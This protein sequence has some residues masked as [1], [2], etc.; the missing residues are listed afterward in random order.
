MVTLL[1]VLQL[2]LMQMLPKQPVVVPWKR[3]QMQQQIQVHLQPNPLR[4]LS[5]R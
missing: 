1:L 5:N 3:K 2:W 4:D